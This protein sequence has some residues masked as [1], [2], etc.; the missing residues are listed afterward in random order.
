M[1]DFAYYDM[2]PTGEDKTAYRKLTS[3][4]VSTTKLGGDDVLAIDPIGLVP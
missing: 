1:S 4:F 2:F 3:D